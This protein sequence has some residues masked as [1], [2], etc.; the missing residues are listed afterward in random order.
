MLTTIGSKERLNFH[1]LEVDNG[2]IDASELQF[3]R[4]VVKM[5]HNESYNC[6]CID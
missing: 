6:F 4:N 1:Y 2:L 3:S 5:M